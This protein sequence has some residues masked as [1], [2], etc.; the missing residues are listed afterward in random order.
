MWD[1]VPRMVSI[2]AELPAIDNLSFVV[3][4]TFVTV[5]LL[6]WLNGFDD[7]RT[8]NGARTRY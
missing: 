5:L 3:L 2:A 1:E 7:P 6:A 8:P 4:A